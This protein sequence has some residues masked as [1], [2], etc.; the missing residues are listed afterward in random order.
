MRE[1]DEEDLPILDA[2]VR[3]GDEAIIRSLRTGRETLAALEALRRAALEP[4]E[5]GGTTVP[6]HTPAPEGGVAAGSRPG[7]GD[8]SAVVLDPDTMR[9]RP[10]RRVASGAPVDVVLE[11][12]VD[13]LRR[14]LRELLGD[15]PHGARV[16]R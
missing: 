6:P 8:G 3:V 13:A 2:V 11:R 9:P 4:G 5:C 7:A 16:G 12:H 14:E 15:A 1:H 10:G